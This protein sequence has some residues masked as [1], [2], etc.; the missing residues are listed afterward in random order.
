MPSVKDRKEP[1][2]DEKKLAD[3]QCFYCKEMG[4]VVENCKVRLALHCNNCKENGHIAKK[5]PMPKQVKAKACFKCG[6]T[7]H[8]FAF[9]PGKTPKIPKKKQVINKHQVKVMQAYNA[10]DFP[11]LD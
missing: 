7:D 10:T 4:H 5:C 3:K 6:D 8:I 9:C 11:T 1:G 2:F